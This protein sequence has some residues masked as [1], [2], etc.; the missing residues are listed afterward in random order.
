M[1]FE[2]R[3]EVGLERALSLRFLRGR[4]AMPPTQLLSILHKTRLRMR[5]QYP[6]IA[7]N[8]KDGAP[9]CAGDASE[10]KSLGHPPAVRS[11]SVS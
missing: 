8:A 9:H 3:P 4:V 6:P 5:S 1:P 7:K 11:S 2:W 10:F